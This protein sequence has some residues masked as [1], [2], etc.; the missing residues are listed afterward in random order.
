MERWEK[1]FHFPSFLTFCSKL[2]T[3]SQGNKTGKK[4][5]VE[6]IKD[7]N[8][9][10][11]SFSN[12]NLLGR[13]RVSLCFLRTPISQNSSLVLVLR[14]IKGK[15]SLA[16]GWFR[17]CQATGSLVLWQF[18]DGLWCCLGRRGFPY[19]RVDGMH[20]RK[21]CFERTDVRRYLGTAWMKKKVPDKKKTPKS[22]A[23]LVYF[24]EFFVGETWIWYG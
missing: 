13:D 1:G 14:R 24:L 5:L 16:C 9:S 22:V 11:I 10:R 7:V 12:P 6:A 18:H 17:R 2:L 23:T 21:F 4:T 15:V 19:W 8:L 3:L 20:M